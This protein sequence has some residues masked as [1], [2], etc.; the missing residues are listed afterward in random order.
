MSR[1]HIA[2]GLS[3]RPAMPAWAMTISNP[4]MMFVVHSRTW[5]AR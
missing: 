3:T 5:W 4:S 2:G 1:K